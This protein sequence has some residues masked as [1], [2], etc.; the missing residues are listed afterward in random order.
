MNL[1]VMVSGCPL[2][3]VAT[4]SKS[5]TVPAYLSKGA[6]CW[7]DAAWYQLGTVSE[8]KPFFGIIETGVKVKVKTA[9]VTPIVVEL[10]SRLT[11]F[12]EMV[13][14]T[15]V[16]DLWVL[17]WTAGVSCKLHSLKRVTVKGSILRVEYGF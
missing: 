15:K 5:S 4:E 11:L 7:V 8:I 17:L 3:I 2:L 6:P 13:P 1:C 10:D 12:E 14:A 9:S 16:V